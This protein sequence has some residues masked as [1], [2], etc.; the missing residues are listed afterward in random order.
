MSTIPNRYVAELMTDVPTPEELECLHIDP[1]TLCPEDLKSYNILRVRVQAQ[2]YKLISAI[3]RYNHLYYIESAPEISDEEY[4]LLFHLLETLE[5]KLPKDLVDEHSPTKC[6]GSPML[7]QDTYKH[8]V[9]MYSLSNAYT[10]DHL[11]T[12]SK[13]F[14]QYPSNEFYCDYKLDGVAVELVYRG[15][16]MFLALTRGDGKFGLNITEHANKITNIPTYIPDRKLLVVHGEVVMHRSDFNN[17]N[18]NN[19]YATA[20]NLV[21]GIINS[22]DVEDERHTYLKFYA[23]NCFKFDEDSKYNYHSSK[24]KLLTSLGFQIPKGHV[25]QS[26]DQMMDYINDTAKMR[27]YTIPY[28]IDGVV[29]KHNL[30][31]VQLNLGFNNRSPLWAIAWKFKA[32]GDDTSITNIKWNIGRTG[33]LTPVAS[34]EPIR[35]DGV[36][37]SEV[38]LNNAQY[39]LHNRIGI[40]TKVRVIRSADVIPKIDQVIEPSDVVSV[41]DVCP[42]C[43]TQLNMVGPELRCPNRS[44]TGTFTAYLKYIVSKDVLNVYGVGPEAIN[45]IVTN[46]QLH[47]FLDLFT[48]PIPKDTKS[49]L[50]RLL[51]RCASVSLSEFLLLLCIPHVGK[52]AIN[53]ITIYVKTVCELIDVLTDPDKL[54]EFPVSDRI[55]N[56]LLDWYAQPANKS[57]IDQLRQQHILPSIIGDDRV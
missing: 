30:I 42:I 55:K 22:K 17:L 11:R 40:G 31:T 41:P 24:M 1:S 57:I 21:S 32:L 29:I 48:T 51:S 9:D 4:D 43:G 7:N 26:I 27:N 10:E 37:I 33:K 3:R 50:A 36:K 5:T 23:W 49:P 47:T 45:D 39:V 25:Y 16:Q 12:F 53:R 46:D 35:V 14:S 28:F 20:R 8:I 19:Q 34:I 38:T 54:N 18:I 13:K 52:A 6:V 15:G 2:Y 44:C 56:N